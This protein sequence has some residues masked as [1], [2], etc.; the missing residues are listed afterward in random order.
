MVGFFAVLPAA[1]RLLVLVDSLVV[2]DF[3]T[4]AGFFAVADCLDGV[5]FF[6]AVVFLGPADFL[7][8]A[9]FFTPAGFSSVCPVA[10]GFSLARCIRLMRKRL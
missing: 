5:D 9:G 7:A 3:T 4:E 10:G 8:G 1:L 2:A 6:A